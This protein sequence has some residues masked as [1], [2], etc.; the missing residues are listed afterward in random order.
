MQDLWIVS[1]SPTRAAAIRRQLDGIFALHVVELGRMADTEPPPLLLCDVDFTN[2]SQVASLKTWLRRKPKDGKVVFAVDKASHLQAIQAKAL[3][4][5]GVLHRPL[6]R[7]ALVKTLLGDLAALSDDNPGDPIKTSPGVGQAFDALRTVF[8]A[9]CFGTRLDPAAINQGGE[10]VM[11][12]MEAQGLGSWLDTVRKHHSQTY[13]HCLIVTGVTVGFAQHLGL[14][15]PDQLRLAF[16]AMLH[17]IGKA[18]IPIEILEKPSAPTAEEMAVLRKHPEYGLEALE[19]S[20]GLSAELLDLVVHHHEYLD[21]SGYPHGLNGAE[22]PDPVRIM[23]ICDIFGA[24]I[25][26]RAYKPPL[27]ADV[28]YQMLRDMGDKLDKDLVREFGFVK[29]LRLNVAA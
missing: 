24:L 16:G 18:R 12:R 5:V 10:A 14:S 26:R 28:A 19:S 11:R 27:A 3:G 2:G 13:Q 23:T 4:A 17:D 29:T 20:P 15:R 25:E 9:A 1:D 6:D 8:E 22:I 21:G 7:K